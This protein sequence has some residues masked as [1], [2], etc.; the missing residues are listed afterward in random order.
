MLAHY[1]GKEC[2]D[3]QLTKLATLLHESSTSP[4]TPAALEQLCARFSTVDELRETLSLET[5]AAKETIAHPQPPKGVAAN[6]LKEKNA[7]DAEMEN[8][9]L[10]RQ[11]S[12][13]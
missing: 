1:F 9:K 12:G 11:V 4:M 3:A 2:T 7:G 6:D 5:G 8:S 13:G 10:K